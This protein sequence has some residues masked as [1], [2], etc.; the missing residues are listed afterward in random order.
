MTAENE[1]RG[2][3]RRPGE[4]RP[5]EEPRPGET[6][7][8]AASTPPFPGRAGAQPQAASPQAVADPSSAE[9]EGGKKKR[10]K[11]DRK[12]Q[13]GSSRGIETM[14]RT[15]YRTHIDM[16]SLADSKA[17][18]MISINGLI[19]SI[20]IASISPKIDSNAWLLLPTSVLLV[21]CL[22][23]MVYAVLAARPRVTNRQVS[24]EDERRDRANI[25][26]FGNFVNMDEEDYAEGMKELLQNPESLYL[27]MIRDIYS[28]GRVLAQKFHYLRIAYAVFMVSLIVGV[29]FFLLVLMTVVARTP[30]AI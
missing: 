15:S 27:N 28:L 23:S 22:V 26:F 18:I 25:L 12:S 6:R 19:M 14:F 1:P 2:P 20:L 5:P 9:E 10:K 16:S 17:N 21:G 11:K 29:C 7:Q 13:L 3:S 24:L 30:P 8:R 4:Q